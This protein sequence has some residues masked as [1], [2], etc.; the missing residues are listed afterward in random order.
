MKKSR[1]EIDK[2]DKLIVFLILIIFILILGMSLKTSEADK[3]RH[4]T[5]CTKECYPRQV[6]EGASRFNCYCI[7]KEE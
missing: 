2:T 5:R 6:D 3:A 4:L 7:D 1:S